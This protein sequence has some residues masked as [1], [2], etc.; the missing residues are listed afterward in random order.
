[1][2]QKSNDK[3]QIEFEVLNFGDNFLYLKTDDGYFLNREHSTDPSMA[4]YLG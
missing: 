2:S 1:M 3:S 4:D